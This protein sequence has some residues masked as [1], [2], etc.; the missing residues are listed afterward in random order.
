MSRGRH[1]EPNSAGFWLISD[2]ATPQW[3]SWCPG[4]LAI[5]LERERCSDAGICGRPCQPSR[6]ARRAS[7]PH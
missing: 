5:E 7:M 2:R 3:T 1:V 6:Q 4:I